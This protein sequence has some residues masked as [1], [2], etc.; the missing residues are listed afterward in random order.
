[1]AGS[2]P[3]DFIAAYR[4]VD[5]SAQ[6]YTLSVGSRLVERLGER[7]IGVAIA[8]AMPSASNGATGLGR[9][10]R[11]LA[12]VNRVREPT[13]NHMEGFVAAKVMAEALRRAGKAPTPEDIVY[14]LE[15]M[16]DVDLGGL[17]V[18]FSNRNH[19]GSSFVEMT[20]IGT[21]KRLIR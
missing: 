10:L 15:G 18:R 6:F 7:A 1:M 11:A 3:A 20:V 17:R 4:R 12:E 13:P 5:L 9:E 16:T 21:L 19:N 14:A 2:L 8:Q